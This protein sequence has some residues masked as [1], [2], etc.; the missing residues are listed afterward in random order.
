MNMRRLFV[1]TCCAVAL[2]TKTDPDSAHV[3]SRLG[4]VESIVD[5]RTYALDESIF[6]GTVDKVQKDGHFYSHQPPLLSTIEAPVYWLLRLPGTRF[7]NR[8]RFVMTY[9]FS[10]LTNGVALALTVLL[11]ARM[12]ASMSVGAPWDAVLAVLLVF[13]TWLLPYGL[14]PN[15]HGI[16]GLL[17]TALITVLMKCE[18]DG[19]TPWRAAA[20][21][22][23]LGLLAAVEVLPI[24]SFVPLTIGYFAMRRKLDRAS[25]PA[26]AAALALPL[27]VHALI[28]IRITGDV[29]PAGFHAELF[30]YEGSV[31]DDTTLTG[32]LKYHSIGDAAAYA[33]TSL[34]AY[35]GF[36][37]F[38]P[39]CALG[40][41]AGVVEWRW[42]RA[43]QY[44]AV[45]AI[46]LAGIILSLGAALL[47]TNNYG[48]EAVGFRHAVFLSPACV[49]LLLP[50]IAGE[51]RPLRQVVVAV[52]AVSTLLMLVCAARQPWSVLTLSHAP[53]GGWDEYLPILGKLVH[54][55]LFT[56]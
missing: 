25:W 50:W 40:L 24:V 27:A 11:I 52:A 53:V 37:T 14:V 15:N 41:I 4:T 45:H 20:A 2:L 33:W 43:R 28:N 30:R 17:L 6:I 7:N 48:G 5:R 56:P 9:A 26:L 21:G 32:T 3:M 35:K 31:F 34:F 39:V 55:S 38:A 36:F 22:G 1:V 23:I 51:A 42:W 19:P 13:G 12:L 29:I 46:V 16:S 44:T 54:G 47:T 18:R 49:I 10:L 8:G